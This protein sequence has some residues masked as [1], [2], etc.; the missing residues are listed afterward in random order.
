M[1]IVKRLAEAGATEEAIQTLERLVGARLPED[2]RRF[3]GTVNGG[4][5]DPSGFVFQTNQGTSD[6]SIR[7]FLTLDPREKIYTIPAYMDRYKGRIPSGMLAI[8]CDSFGNLV[9][10]DISAR[11]PGTV[12]FWDHEE[13]N[14]DEV[15]WENIFTA[16]AS[17][18]DLESAL[19]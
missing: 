8:A 2:Y 12:Y 6:C 14:M 11:K 13:E 18:T 16:A 7:Y 17:F 4:R 5:P 15:T 9:L 10:L 19:A 1:R 3:L